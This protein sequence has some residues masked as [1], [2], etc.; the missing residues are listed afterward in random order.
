MTGYYCYIL[1]TDIFLEAATEF[2]N[3][4]TKSTCD[5]P[6]LPPF[7]LSMEYTTEYTE[8]TL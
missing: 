8:T 2:G 1:R 3:R 4:A 5:P 6:P 7:I